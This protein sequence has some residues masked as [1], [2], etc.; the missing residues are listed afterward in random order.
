MNI[1][2]LGY[3]GLIGS[4]ILGYLSKDKSFN[5]ICIGR[6]IENKPYINSRIKYF[7]WDYKTFKQSELFFLKTADIIINCVGKTGELESEI[8]NININFIKNFLNF[9]KSQKLK[10]RFIH[11]SSVSVYGFNK[12]YFGKRIIL[13]ENSQVRFNGIYSRSKYFSEK[14]LKDFA[15]NQFKDK[16]SYT[17]LR[18]SNTYG[19][20]NKSNLFN[21]IKLSL[22][23]NIWLKCFDDILFNFV[24]VKDVVQAVTL[25]I[26]NLKITK[27]KTY[28]VS[29]DCNQ[30]DIYRNYEKKFQKKIFKIQ[31]PVSLI[32]FLFDF[33][34]LPKKIENLILLISSRVSY[35]NEKIRNELSFNPKYPLKNNIEYLNE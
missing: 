28:I 14:F 18:I 29:D 20:K 12:K 30:L 5:I 10:F 24:N 16:F 32:R 22:K 31:M 6:K 3:T 23:V 11:L 21:Y 4:N 2:I 13:N 35:S 34:P 15:Y 1:V 17:I 33:I 9:S 8:K 25:V 26:S 27:N 7:K 19:G